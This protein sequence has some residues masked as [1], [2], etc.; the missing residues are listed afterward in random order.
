MYFPNNEFVLD[1]CCDAS[2]FADRDAMVNCGTMKKEEAH[3]Y[4]R[5]SVVSN[6]KFTNNIGLLSCLCELALPPH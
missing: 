6:L 4:E 3:V 1:S 2:Y 5:V